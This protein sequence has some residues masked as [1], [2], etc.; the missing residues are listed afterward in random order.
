MMLLSLSIG[1]I[2]ACL[3]TPLKF[4]IDPEVLWLED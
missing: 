4:N 3:I 1:L 2:G